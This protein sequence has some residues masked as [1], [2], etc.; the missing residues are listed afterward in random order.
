MK[1]KLIYAGCCYVVFSVGV[2]LT[3]KII[4]KM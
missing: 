2:Y 1:E 4:K 3:A